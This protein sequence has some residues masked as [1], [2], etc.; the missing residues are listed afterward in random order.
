VLS[1][2]TAGFVLTSPITIDPTALAGTVTHQASGSLT[3]RGVSKPVNVTIVSTVRD[4]QILLA[5][6]VAVV[7]AEWAIPNPS[8][9]GIST[10]DSG[11]LE[12]QLVLSR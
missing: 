5:G 2:P 12:F 6:E 3:L 1:Y 10:E 9:P 7:F 8:I 4:T 11:V